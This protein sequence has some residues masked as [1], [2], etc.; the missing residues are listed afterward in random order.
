MTGRARKIRLTDAGVGRLRPRKT[1]YVVWD[2]QVAG[3]GVRVRPSGHRS[4][5]WH[6]H[7]NGKAVRVTVGS[8]AMTTVEEAR[9]E[10][11]MLQNGMELSG[12][13]DWS[14]P[15]GTTGRIGSP[16]PFFRILS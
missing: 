14:F 12:R 3:L 10:C 11:P 8:A 13:N 6:G 7:A 5:V 15:E 16:F 4:F 2:S 1:E 9:R